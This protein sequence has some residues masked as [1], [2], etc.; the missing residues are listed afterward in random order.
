ME[1]ESTTHGDSCQ[2]T[3]AHTIKTS[4]ARI[5]DGVNLEDVQEFARLFKMRRQQLNMTQTQVGNALALSQGPTYSQSAICRYVLP[6]LPASR[7][8]VACTRFPPFCSGFP[9]QQQ[10]FTPNRFFSSF[11][12]LRF[13]KLDISPKSALKIMPVLKE[14]MAEAEKLH[15]SGQLTMTD[16]VGPDSNKKRKRRTTFATAATERLNQFFA[17][18]TQHPDSAQ[19]TALASELDYDREVIRVWFCNRRQAL[20]KVLSKSSGHISGAFDRDNS[21]TANSV[22]PVS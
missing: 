19:M 6:Q 10:L 16:V 21:A 5:V 2:A 17:E 15:K 20:K 9:R 1:P 12:C 22:I 13:E 11:L 18:V 8:P 4:S 14:W 7:L 3:I